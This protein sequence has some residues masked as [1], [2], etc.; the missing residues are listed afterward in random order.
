MSHL[1]QHKGFGDGSRN[2]EPRSSDE[3]DNGAGN[4][5]SKQPHHS[6]GRT[7][8][9]DRFNVYQPPLHIKSSVDHN[10]QVTTAPTVWGKEHI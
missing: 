10:N 9:F 5:L 8:S 1:K 2:F 4:S 3:D 6:K 7:L